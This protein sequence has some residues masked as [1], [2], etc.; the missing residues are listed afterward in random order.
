M[1][2]DQRWFDAGMA[3]SMHEPAQQ[4]SAKRITADDQRVWEVIGNDAPDVLV[5]D[6][7]PQVRQIVASYLT[8]EGFSVRTAADGT[9]A[10]AELAKKRPDLVVLDLMLP[11]VDGLTVLRRLRASGDQVPVIVLSAKGQ[12]SERVAG[13]ELGADDYLAKPASPREV[14][15]RVRAV[16]RRSGSSGPETISVGDLVID[17]T[18]RRLHQA[19]T[20]VEVT[21]KEFDLLATLAGAPGEVHSRSDLLRDVWG[22]SPDW[23]DPGTVTV[24]MR[25]LRRKLET[26]PANPV[27]LVTVYGVGYRFD[28]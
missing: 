4:T 22:S 10:M 23:Q 18:G 12:E 2:S 8:R 17:V 27:H 16:L 7:E 9:A 26:D 19:G 3:A 1:A 5:V 25:R 20:E 11:G 28:P 6:D 24:H 14:A 15:A 13:L 21:P